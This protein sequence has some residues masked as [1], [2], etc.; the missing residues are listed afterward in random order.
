[1]KIINACY[2]NIFLEEMMETAR[3]CRQVRWC[4]GQDFNQ[5]PPKYEFRLL[6]LSDLLGNGSQNEGIF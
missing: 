4:P 1:M 3:N 2:S 6:P 5:S